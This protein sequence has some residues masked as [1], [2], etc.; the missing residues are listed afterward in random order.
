L[1]PSCHHPP[2]T[3]LPRTLLPSGSGAGQ[4]VRAGGG[5]PLEGKGRQRRRW[6]PWTPAA[7]TNPA[8]RRPPWRPIRSSPRRSSGDPRC[9]WIRAD[10]TIPRRAGG[11]A[12]GTRRRSPPMAVSMVVGLP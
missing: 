4:P 3:A 2:S 9:A 7:M 12:R 6:P 11:P 10:P 5:A 8:A 1:N